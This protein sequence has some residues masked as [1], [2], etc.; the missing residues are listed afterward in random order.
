MLVTFHLVALGW[1]LFRAEDFPQAWHLLSTLINSSWQLTP[2]VA[3]AL[4]LLGF[5]LLP[6][7][8]V[9][10]WIERSGDDLVV[11]RLHW[12]LRAMLYAWLLA[13]IV[14]FPPPVP[15]EFIYFQF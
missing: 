14:F 2:Y 4:S 7:L 1:L 10:G 12:L 3:T 11:L 13:M 8:V 9:E 5:Y 6:W 15:A